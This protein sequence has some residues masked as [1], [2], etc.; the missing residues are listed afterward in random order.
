MSIV[1][2]IGS[3]IVVNKISAIALVLFI[4]GGAYYAINRP[5]PPL[6]YETA[7]VLL[8]DVLQEVS[9]TGRVVPESEVELSFERGGR[10]A[11]VGKRVGEKTV[12]GDMLVTLD[13]SETETLLAQARANLT[14]ETAKLDE[15][16]AGARAEDIRVSEAEVAGAWVTRDEAARALSDKLDDAATKADDAV[17]NKTDHLLR[18]P[19]TTYPEVDFPMS[20][21][22]LEV[23]IVNA[24]IGVEADIVAWKA[25]LSG[26]DPARTATEVKIS[27]AN[28]KAY[29][30]KLAS[31]V[32]I[33][34][35][36]TS[37]SQTTIDSWKLDVSTARTT[38]NTTI[39]G[40]IAAE[41][42]YRSADAALLVAENRLALKRSGA[43]AEQIAAQEARIAAQR[44]AIANYIAQLSKFTIVAPFSGVITRQDAKRGATVVAGVPLVALE[45]AS[46]AKIEANIPEADIAKV[47]VGNAAR[48]TLDAYGADVAFTATV[49][50]I[51]PAETIVEGV[52]TYKVTLRFAEEDAR[53]RSGMT[54]NIDIAAAKKEGVLKIPARAVFTKNEKKF[55]R[56]PATSPDGV[57]TTTEFMIETGLRGSDGSIEVV[58]GLKEN[59]EVVMFVK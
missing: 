38:I 13:A 10:V 29:L 2:R 35:S 19:K 5:T 36:S 12:R 53:I 39:S 8:G 21:N 59:Q 37:V 40:V 31:A 3:W 51:D 47:A 46:S 24:R 11:E 57:A 48:V 43:T 34:P 27:L 33:V 42:A 22:K 6:P 58:S 26:A 44:A 28:I 30:D 41:T 17:Y 16:K 9:V 49:A 1:M 25:H 14:Y 4:G 18:N 20:D 56:I 55:I 45:S 23:E 7:R 52:P 32:N 54:A 15:L 50:A